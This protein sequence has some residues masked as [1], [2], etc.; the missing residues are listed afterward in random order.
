[1]FFPDSKTLKYH[2]M[3]KYIL[4]LYVSSS[5]VFEFQLFHDIIDAQQLLK[6][7]FNHYIVDLSDEELDAAI[8]NGDI[9]V[10]LDN[11]FIPYDYSIYDDNV[12]CIIEEIKKYD[13][14]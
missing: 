8:D 6:E 7:R 2:A 5:D 10:S 11:F 9:N 1:M 13:V 12:S 14:V 3:P 4:M